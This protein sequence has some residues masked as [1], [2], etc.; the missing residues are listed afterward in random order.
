MKTK[1]TATIRASAPAK[2]TAHVARGL[3]A[4]GGPSLPLPLGEGKGEGAGA[5]QHTRY[6]LLLLAFSLSA[7][8]PFSPFTHAAPSSR[9]AHPSITLSPLTGAPAEITFQNTPA[10]LKFTGKTSGGFI[11]TD[12]NAKKDAPLRNGKISKTE[13]GATLYTASSPD[14]ILRATFTPGDNCIE[15]AGEIESTKP[16]DRALIVRYVLP[17]PAAGALF[18]NSL[19]PADAVRLGSG[20]KAL[21]TVYPIATLTGKD[22][23]ASISI[24]PD[25]PC[26][27]GVT[28]G[29]EGLG[30][31]FYLG[32]TPVTRAFPNKAAFKFT[33]GPTKTSWGFRGA[34]EDYY[35]RNPDFYKRR[36][37]RAGLWNWNDPAGIGTEKETAA[38]PIWPLFAAH[39][40]PSHGA[41]FKK[42]LERNRRHGVLTFAYTIIGMREL[43][44]LPDQ[45]KDYDTMMSVF[46]KFSAEWA[47]Q[48]ATGEALRK[49]YIPPQRNHNL[50]EQINTSAM[51]DE[52]GKLRYRARETAWGAHSIT[53][54]PNPNPNLFSDKRLDTVGSVTL[55]MIE[56]WFKNNTADGVHMDSLGSQWP[57]WI[58]YRAEHFPYAIYPLTFDKNGRIGLHNMISHYEFLDATRKL[59]FKHNKLI[60]G[61]GVDLY[62]RPKMDEHYNSVQNGRFFLA[63]QLDMT[64]RE[65]TSDM[66]SRERLE[67]YRICLGPKLMT[68]ILYEWQE[69]DLV[70]LQMEQALAFGIFAAPNRSFLDQ[71]SYILAPNGFARDKDF[72][73][74]FVKNARILHDAGW[75]PVTYARVDSPAAKDIACERYGRGGEIYF[76]LLNFAEFPVDCTLRVALRN[77]GV[78]GGK[79]DF[80]EI[81]RGA[82]LKAEAA[83]NVASV[84][85]KLDPNKTYIIK[86]SK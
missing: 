52:N 29:D 51:H 79:L 68:A 27:F 6:S 26:C 35:K 25:S 43:T 32:V 44:R 20:A 77:L 4:A 10:P 67:S 49:K 56:D 46:N 71:I 54:I 9:A 12:F 64:G 37:D 47:R 28:G 78:A 61:N 38:E 74:W 69:Q 34:L 45:P 50:I 3:A 65:I 75:E 63:A 86:L 82:Q 40:L 23:G 80:S 14:L 70:K 17:L 59:A 48:D 81:A 57:C 22:W 7:L 84:T 30:V 16:V 31:E 39:G 62:R 24:P 60:F 21:G 5:S 41:T 66:M 58:N 33:I 11:I 19:N 15:V 8:Q 2:T 72:L 83:G 55:A 42:Q 13:T 73:E 18:E 85:L 36:N 53:F 1:S 76:T